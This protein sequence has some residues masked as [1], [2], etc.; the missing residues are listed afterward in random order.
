MCVSSSIPSYSVAIGLVLYASIYLYLLFYHEDY[1]G[2]FNRFIIYIVGIDLLLSAFYHLSVNDVTQLNEEHLNINELQSINES[3]HVY[4]LNNNVDDDSDSDIDSDINSD[5]STQLSYN[6]DDTPS[7]EHDD[8]PSIQH[9][10][11]PSIQ[12]DDNSTQHSNDNIVANQTQNT[13]DQSPPQEVQLDA[14]EPEMV[15]KRR[16]RPPKNSISQH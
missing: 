5:N 3:E 14:T 2:I 6:I 16:G 1:I 8:T 9:D 13:L 7:I 10:D 12:H 11:T 4:P 15:K